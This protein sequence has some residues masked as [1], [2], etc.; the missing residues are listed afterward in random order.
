MRIAFVTFEYPPFI[1]GGAGVYALNVTQELAKLGHKIIVFTPDI[2]DTKEEVYNIDNLEIVKIKIN[3]NLPLKS[4]QFWLSLPKEIRTKEIDKEFD[5]VHFNG[6]SYHFLINKISNASHIITIHHLVRD[7]IKNNKVNL[8]SKIFNISSENNFILPF[9]E[10]MN[11]NSGHK[12][13]SVS[14]FTKKQL[15]D[16]YNLNPKQIEVIHNGI[17]SKGYS[18]SEDELNVV[19]KKLNIADK[20]VILFVGR[21]NDPRKGLDFLLCSLKLISKIVDV[22]LIVVGS[23]NQENAIKL[24]ESLGVSKNVLFV[25]YADEIDLKKYYSLC[26]IYVCPSRLEGFGLTILEAMVAGKS[27]VA[28][29]VGAIPEIV[30]QENGILVEPGDLIGMSNAIIKLLQDKELAESMGQRN[31]EYAIHN[32]SWETSGKKMS[33]LY[34]TLTPPSIG[35]K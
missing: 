22:M 29:N 11:V 28:T 4:L 10:K 33:E 26:D 20:A 14:N 30:H 25:G 18:F 12:I 31:R 35:N 23:G 2:A 21:I 17:D 9:V 27:I 5:I 15:I 19:R 16:T 7:A 3:K 8:F 13:I 6:I 32:F 24:S 34:H 1:I